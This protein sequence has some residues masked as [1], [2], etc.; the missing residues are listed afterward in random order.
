[1]SFLGFTSGDVQQESKVENKSRKRR[2]ARGS[3]K[4][5]YD[6]YALQCI[7]YVKLQSR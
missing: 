6:D 5:S 1:M 4:I 2:N 3:F 7:E